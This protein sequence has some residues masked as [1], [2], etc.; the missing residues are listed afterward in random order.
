MFARLPIFPFFDLQ[1]R[2]V[3]LH[4]VYT[5]FHSLFSSHCAEIL[6]TT[7]LID[8]LR[9]EWHLIDFISFF[10]VKALAKTCHR[11]HQNG[12]S[13][14]LKEF[15]FVKCVMSLSYSTLSLIIIT[16]YCSCAVACGVLLL[17]CVLLARALLVCALLVCALLICALLICALLLAC[18]MLI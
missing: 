8:N 16:S 11:C 10:L 13:L 18:A 9:H 15:L 4:F 6:A 12:K 5:P 1:F 17:A 2:K 14:I 3:S 7:F